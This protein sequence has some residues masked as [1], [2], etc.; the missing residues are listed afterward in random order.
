MSLE[1]KKHVTPDLIKSLEEQTGM[2]IGRVEYHEVNSVFSKMK[3]YIESYVGEGGFI[4]VK[5][6]EMN[7]IVETKE[8]S[9]LKVHECITLVYM[10][11]SH[12]R[13]S[14]FDEDGIEL[15]RLWIKSENQR[16]GLGT[17]LMEIFEDALINIL[18]ELPRIRLECNGSI[19][20]GQNTQHTPIEGQVNF[21]KRFGYE[22]TENMENDGL[23][24]LMK[25]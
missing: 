17:Y 20:F 11:G 22:T 14:P 7:T 10:D 25:N 12:L 4:Q 9:T 16:I 21:F 1:F 5:F 23:V 19:G 2:L 18:G 3:E 15:T 13:F 8:H 6:G 24:K